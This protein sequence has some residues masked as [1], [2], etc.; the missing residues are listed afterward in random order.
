MAE[1]A[2][3]I[4]PVTSVI[5][6]V[7]N[8][9]G[10]WY[11][12]KEQKK[13]NSAARALQEKLFYDKLRQENTQF[14]ATMTQRKNEFGT[15]TRLTKAQMKAAER[16]QRTQDALSRKT[17]AIRETEGQQSYGLAKEAQAANIGLN[18]RGMTLQESQ[19]ATDKETATA[20]IALGNRGM[21]IQ[22]KTAEAQI[23]ANKFNQIT[24]LM[25]NMTNFY[26][27]P[28]ARSQ[29]ATLYSGYRR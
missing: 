18:E 1:P 4:N 17:L 12:A 28:G 19:A 10:S 16:A 29:L 5:S 6:G 15:T 22:E 25:T 3:S 23:Q 21:A 11:A 24:Q 13:E 8:F 14:D 9:A 7:L 27:T 20:N 26:N 2:P